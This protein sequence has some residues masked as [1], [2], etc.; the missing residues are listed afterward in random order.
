M[1]RRSG[2][3]SDAVWE[4]LSES[5]QPMTWRTVAMRL[6]ERRVINPA[7][8]S[9]ARLVRS[10]ISRLAS[11]GRLDRVGRA[12]VPGVNRGMTLFKARPERSAVASGAGQ[13]LQQLML[14]AWR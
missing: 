2:A 5:A 11:A 1:A 6:A 14:A 4:T 9:E 13:N 12:A 8:P 10:T 3:L 7:A